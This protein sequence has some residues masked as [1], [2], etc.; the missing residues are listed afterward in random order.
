MRD[1][2]YF[3]EKDEWFR[4]DFEKRMYVLTDQ[5]TEKAKESYKEYVQ[6]LKNG[7]AK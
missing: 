7:K 1:M 4:F 3:M 2:P 5:A 6:G